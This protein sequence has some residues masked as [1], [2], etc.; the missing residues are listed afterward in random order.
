MTDHLHAARCEETLREA[1]AHLADV[2]PYWD[3]AARAVATLVELLD[4][5]TPPWFHGAAWT[6]LERLLNDIVSAIDWESLPP[7]AEAA[8]ALAER[9]RSR[10]VNETQA[11]LAAIAQLVIDLLRLGAA[12]RALESGLLPP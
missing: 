3:R 12:R 5:Q 7:D 2:D 6:Q 9:F 10:S 4:L 1:L 8:P 11:V